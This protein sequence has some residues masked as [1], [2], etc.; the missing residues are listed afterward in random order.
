MSEIIGYL[1]FSDWLISLSVIHSSSIHVVADGKIS[2]FFIAEQ[3]SVVYKPH[4]LYPFSSRLVNPHSYPLYG[5]P[6][7]CLSPHHPLGRL[8]KKSTV[9]VPPL[10][11]TPP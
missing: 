5:S 11:K 7:P 4:L 10:P 2:F 1:S 8:S 9:V 3:Y 6:A